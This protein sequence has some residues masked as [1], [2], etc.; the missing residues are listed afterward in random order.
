MPVN[1]F[2]IK[3]LKKEDKTIDLKDGEF[4]HF[5][6]VIRVK[7]HEE[8]ELINGKGLLTKAKVEKIHK[9][10]SSLNIL[11]S[12]FK[13]EKKHKTIL[14]QA[15]IQP[16]KLDLII[17]KATELGVDEI[18]L[19]YAIKSEKINFSE[20]RL[21]RLENILISACKQSSRLY[22]PK[23]LIFKSLKDISFNGTIYYGSTSKAPLFTNLFKKDG[24]SYFVIGPSSG[25]E[26]EETDYL[27]HI[28]AKAVSL[29]EN[30]LRSETAAIAS[31]CLMNHFLKNN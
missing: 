22:L 12:I 29:N 15:I 11:S 1:R 24:R 8:I 5:K 16:L 27:D 28:K 21:A 25:F 3:E 6:N 4:H 20:N 9:N 7:E 31:I 19:F 2:Y 26:N 14:A 13:E 23:L 18:C 17:E 30:I 10:Y